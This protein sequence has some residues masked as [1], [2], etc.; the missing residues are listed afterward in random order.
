V[1]GYLFPSYARAGRPERW[2]FPHAA[3]MLGNRGGSKLTVDGHS[4]LRRPAGGH[5]PAAGQRAS[6]GLGAARRRLP[7][8]TA[9]ASFT[10]PGPTT[11]SQTSPRR[12]SNAGPSS[13]ASSTNTSESRKRPGQAP[14]PSSGTPHPVAHTSQEKI[15]RRAVLGGL[16][17]EYERA[18]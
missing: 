4:G 13:A 5:H 10:R 14:R 11:P 1:P 16:I 8:R 2:A 15:K 12:R 7:G 18:A 17:N 6:A 9:A 3:D